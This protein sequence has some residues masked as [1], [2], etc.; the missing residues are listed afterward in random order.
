MGLIDK[1]SEQ[2]AAA[3]D[4]A[5]A[6]IAL[7]ETEDRDLTA[8]EFGQITE[9]RE[10]VDTL[11]ARIAE[12]Q[13]VEAATVAAAPAVRTAPAVV[14]AEARTYSRQA[15]REGVSFLSDVA[16]RLYGDQDAAGRLARHMAEERVERPGIEHR[17]VGTSAFVNL[18]VPQ[19]LTDLYAPNAKKGRPF[20]N[21]CNRHDLPASGM[22]VEISRITTGSSTAVQSSQNSAVS[23][24]NMDDI[25]LSISVQTIAGQQTVSRQALERGTGIEGVVLGDLTRSYHSTLDDTL[26]NQATNGLDA[27]T[28]ANVDIAYTD[29]TPSAAEL[30]PK[31]FDGIQQIQSAVYN[32]ASSNAL[33]MHPRRFWWLASQVGT[34]FPFVNLSGAGPQSG[35][36]VD[37]TGY[38]SGPSGFLAGLPVFVD[39]NI[40]TN[41]GG[42]TEDRVYI[43]STDECH[44][45][46]DDA[47]FIRAEQTNAASL[48][49]LFVVYGYMAYTFGRYPSAN[50]RI[51][52]TGLVTPT[53]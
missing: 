38:E 27:V 24:T 18:T 53:F 49:V 21:I 26:I 15:E 17:A 19:Y 45:W 36:S 33:V 20:A 41:G 2:R 11:D 8:D 6:L 48:G 10:L 46:E 23:E 35:G 47:L 50:A 30:W 25:A 29:A 34:N 51:A 4:A 3:H 12:I 37:G 52:G 13:R 7:A 1:L 14:K 39:A 31:L 42:G 28:D 44:L 16:G 40:V 32:L 9:N 22:T 5:L 43:V